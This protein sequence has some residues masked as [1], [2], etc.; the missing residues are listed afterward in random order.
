MKQLSVDV[1]KSYLVV[2]PKSSKFDPDRLESDNIRIMTFLNQ[3]AFSKS[4]KQSYERVLRAFFAFYSN[5]GV[6]EITDIHIT[7]YLKSIK[8]SPATRNFSL[9]AISSLYSNLVKTGYV[10]KNPASTLSSEKV[11]NQLRFKILDFSQIEHMIEL[12]SMFRNK[13]LLKVLYYTGTRITEALSLKKGSFRDTNDGGAFMTVLGKGTKVRTVYVPE[14]IYLELKQY[15][16]DQNLADSEFIFQSKGRDIT[17]P[18]TRMQAWR[19]VKQAAKKAKIDPLP[20]PHWFRHSSAT[21]AIEN[22][23][24]IH[25][26]QHSLGHS[27][28]QTTSHYLHATPTKSNAN[29]LK[30][31]SSETTY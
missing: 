26:V 16:I 21:H 1:K 30:R 7:L 25:V 14:D 10:E 27:N 3:P 13:I 24:P 15:F 19:I 4:T 20:S 23:A 6:K 9:M 28:I 5:F 8:G 17:L 12:E 18:I 22:G 11:P 2:S 29:Y 31:K